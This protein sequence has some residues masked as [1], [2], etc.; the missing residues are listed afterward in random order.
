MGLC[1]DIDIVYINSI[2]MSNIMVLNSFMKHRQSSIFDITKSCFAK[3]TSS[4]S[5]Y[6]EKST[7]TNYAQENVKSVN[8]S[9][10]KFL[11]DPNLL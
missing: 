3:N 5:L 1:R 7:N 11:C 6:Q 2:Y 10:R 8:Q 9:F 4:I